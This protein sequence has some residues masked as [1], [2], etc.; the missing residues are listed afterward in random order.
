MGIFFKKK[1]IFARLYVCQQA[2]KLC[3]MDYE[4]W[5]MNYGLW[6]MDYGL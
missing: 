2:T 5:T 3:T 1:Y 6:T 4:L